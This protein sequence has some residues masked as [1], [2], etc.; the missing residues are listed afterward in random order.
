MASSSSHPQAPWRALH[1]S[2]VFVWLWTAF[3]SLWEFHGTS[4]QLLTPLAAYPDWF[5]HGLIVGGALADAL[6]GVWLWRRPGRAAYAV[7]GAAMAAMTVLAT[8]L[9][10]GL[11][12]HPLGP[13]SK[14]LP[15]AAALWLLWRHAPAHSFR[16]PGSAS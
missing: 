4:V 6:I 5:K 8:A 7:A 16:S 9:H 3:A 10:P 2:V 13:L 11:W 1:A 14:N 15:I 12:L